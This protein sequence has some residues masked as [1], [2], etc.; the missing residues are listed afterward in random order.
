MRF[1][2]TVA[3]LSPSKSSLHLPLCLEGGTSPLSPTKSSLRFP[4]H[5][6]G[7]G[8]LSLAV[9]PS[10]HLLSP[11]TRAPFFFAPFAVQDILGQ[12]YQESNEDD[13]MKASRYKRQHAKVTSLSI[14][15]QVF[16]V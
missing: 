16:Y 11:T 15:M 4:S 14:E 6:E 3:P 12:I 1:A 2:S 5:L 9:E 10:L 13:F 7:V 8:R